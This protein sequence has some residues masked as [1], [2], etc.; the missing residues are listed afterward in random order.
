MCVC[1]LMVRCVS[2]L[3]KKVEGGGLMITHGVVVVV[4]RRSNNCKMS[5]EHF[6]C[7]DFITKSRFL[8]GVCF[9]WIK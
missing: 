8:D 6:Y 2:G 4:V 9:F 7:L 5:E 3:G 1:V